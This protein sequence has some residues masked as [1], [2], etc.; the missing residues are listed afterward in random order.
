MSNKIIALLILIWTIS[1]I[2]WLYFYFFVGYTSAVTIEANIENY[3]VTLYSKRFGKSFDYQCPDMTCVLWDVSPLE[4]NLRINKE[5]YSWVFQDID[6]KARENLSLTIVAQKKV[7]LDQVEVQEVDI[8]NKQRISFLRDKK[9]AYSFFDFWSGNYGYFL[10]KGDD[11]L[12]LYIN[13][14][15]SGE[16]VWDF[17]RVQSTALDLQKVS[18]KELLY[19]EI[20]EQ[21]YFYDISTWKIQTLDITVDILYVKP[22]RTETELLFVTSVGTYIYDIR[23]N[24]FE[25]VSLFKDF[26]YQDDFYIGVIFSDE[27]QKLRNFGWE[28]TTANLIV[29]YNPLTKEKAILYETG[30]DIE[31]IYFDT[32]IYFE[33]EGKRYGLENY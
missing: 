23:Q 19:F 12:S 16:K 4:Y 21:R 26:I 18:Q 1:G 5:G 33:S 10:E 9:R 6:V 32:W 3:N 24:I 11:K 28:D 25:Y 31:K 30:L 13:I 8:S 7:S 17:S 20:G 14:N 27:K 29:K 22:G 2:F 15:E